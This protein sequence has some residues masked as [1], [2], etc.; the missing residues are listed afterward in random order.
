MFSGIVQGKGKILKIV[1]KKNHISLE[2]SAPKNFNKR[3]KKGASISVNGICLTSLD[4]GEKSLK[5]D[6]INETL[7]KTN[8]S[9]ASKGSIVNLERSITAS[10]EIGGHLMSGHIHFA[11]KVEKVL[12]KNTNK[13][14][15]IKFPKKYKE[16][17]FEK[18]YIGINGCSLTLGKINNNSF[19]VH[20]IPET[21]SVTNLNTL[22]KGSQV[23]IEIDQNTIAIVETVKNS[24]AAQESR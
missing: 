1:S 15:Q 4:D 14:V 23:N 10:T 19:F 16:Y 20:L 5:F 13:D 22:K 12:T 3:L 2:I 21:L 9:K 7:S 6:V 8:I 24:L 18:G 17:I 11:G